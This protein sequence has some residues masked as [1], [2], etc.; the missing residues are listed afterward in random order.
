M[1]ALVD[2][3]HSALCVWRWDPGYAGRLLWGGRATRAA[4]GFHAARRPGDQQ[5]ASVVRSANGCSGQRAAC[6]VQRRGAESTVCLGAVPG[7]TAHR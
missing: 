1:G 3:P 5:L 4:A 6:S 7:R 2:S